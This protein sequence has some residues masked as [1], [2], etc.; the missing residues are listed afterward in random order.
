[1]AV[2]VVLVTTF[3]ATAQESF[4]PIEIVE[5][6]F[7]GKTIPLRDFPTM[8]EQNYTLEQL[9]VIE[10][11]FQVSGSQNSGENNSFVDPLIQNNPMQRATS[12]QLANFDGLN[13]SESGAI[14]PDPTGAVGPNH[15]VNAVNV[16]IKIFDK[17]GTLLAGP[18]NLGS[19]LGAF[20]NGDPIIMYDQR[21]DRW[22]VSQ[23]RIST[24]ALIIGVSTSPDPTDT[25]NVYSF[26]LN[27]FPDYPHYGTWPGA[28]IVGANKAGQSVYGFER[29]VML[30]GGASPRLVGFNPP[31]LIRNPNT[32]FGPQ[33]ANLIGY[34]YPDDLVD[35]Y[36][37]YL[38]DDDWGSAIS[39]DHLKI[40]TLTL[41]WDNDDFSISAPQEV[42][43]AP[44]N[45]I[46]FPFGS[47][48]IEQP[49]TSQRIDGLGGIVSYMAN[50]RTFDTHNSFLLNFNVD[51]DGN[52]TSG[53]RWIE[54]RNTGGDGAF[55]V[56][57][58]G[59]FVQPDG[60]SAFMGST[61]MDE[62]G[63]IALAYNVG[64]SSTRAA[65]RYTYRMAA[66]PMGQMTGAETSFVAVSYTHLTLPT[67]YSV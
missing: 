30:A 26:P 51:I 67:I 3:S 35:G 31:S 62:D 12:T 20:G 25:Y 43:T 66:D 64:S 57:Q 40:W 45:S 61:N 54:L 19:F 38:Q 9:N 1:M 50:Y 7:L 14:P 46:F 36:L 47:G 11:Q 49:G 55:S 21:A 65:I 10:Q 8:Q 56:F 23:F 41:D 17:D 52:N 59:T 4:P 18:T 29:E 39:E 2:F 24:D 42:P 32:V 15:Y 48:D 34:D 28:Y 5:G 22:F 33:P 60:D 37:V 27:A 63:N 13:S 6:T 16:A 44:F 53:I 58:E